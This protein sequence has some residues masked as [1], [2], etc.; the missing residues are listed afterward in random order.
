MFLSQPAQCV[1]VPSWAPVFRDEGDHKVFWH[2]MEQ[3]EK[4]TLKCSVLGTWGCQ[5]QVTPRKKSQKISS[6][7]PY[8]TR[9]PQ[10]GFPVTFRGCSV[11]QGVEQLYSFTL[12]GRSSCA[13]LAGLRTVSPQSRH[14][15]PMPQDV[16]FPIPQ[17]LSC[18]CHPFSTRGCGSR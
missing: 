7:Y 5:Q 2:F 1:Q 18:V 14:P 9:S 17:A 13:K 12:G 10:L 8:S 11:A 15:P 6:L 4:G 3:R 16:D